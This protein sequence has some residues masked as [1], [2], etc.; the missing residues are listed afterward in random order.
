[1]AD[2]IVLFLSLDVMAPLP[3]RGP[4]SKYEIDKNYQMV[5][6]KLTFDLLSEPLKVHV[7][8]I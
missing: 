5:K 7:H 4:C 2:I 6:P 1:M 3:F 8:V